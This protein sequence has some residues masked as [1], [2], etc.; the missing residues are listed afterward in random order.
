MES[1]DY[2]RGR[3]QAEREAVRGASCEEARWA[4]E[5][6]AQAY[7]RLIELEELKACG[8]LPAGKVIN[9]A[10]A[11]R[12]RGDSEYGRRRAAPAATRLP[13]SAGRARP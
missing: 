2:F 10:D 7:A 8:S 12:A 11:L 3:E 1:I 5:Q 13:A 4:H 9:V 6:L